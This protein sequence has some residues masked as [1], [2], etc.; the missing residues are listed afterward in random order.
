[1]CVDR[2]ARKKKE[3]RRLEKEKEEAE[4]EV[5]RA[6]ATLCARVEWTSAHARHHIHRADDCVSGVLGGGKASVGGSDRLQQ[7]SS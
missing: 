4:A 5:G 1:M 6:H 7:R 2:T 3:E